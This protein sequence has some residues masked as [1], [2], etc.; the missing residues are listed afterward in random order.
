MRLQHD[1]LMS[2]GIPVLLEPSRVLIV[3]RISQA[4]SCP[5]VEIVVN[6]GHQLLKDVHSLQ[7]TTPSILSGV[8]PSNTEIPNVEDK[9][10][11]DIHRSHDECPRE[12][13]NQQR[14]EPC[15]EHEGVEEDQEEEDKTKEES[16]VL[17]HVKD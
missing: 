5:L 10:Q 15:C 1:Q 9:S 2:S 4:K 6:D 12:L 17:D 14:E 11:Y 7:S 3:L 16:N 8:V 13:A